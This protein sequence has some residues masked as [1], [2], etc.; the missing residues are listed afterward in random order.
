MLHY[1]QELFCC[2]PFLWV[3]GEGHFDKVMEAGGPEGADGLVVN[4]PIGTV[5]PT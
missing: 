3:L 1:C 5:S 2:G 4:E